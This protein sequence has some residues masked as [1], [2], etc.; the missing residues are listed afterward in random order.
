MCPGRGAELKTGGARLQPSPNFRGRRGSGAGLEAGRT[1]VARAITQGSRREGRVWRGWLSPRGRWVLVMQAPRRLRP[2]EVD[3]AGTSPRLVLSACGAA[4][5]RARRGREVFPDR[6]RWRPTAL[7]ARHPC[8]GI[9]RAREWSR[10]RSRPIRCRVAG[11]YKSQRISWNNR[12]APSGCGRPGLC[13][14]RAP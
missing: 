9:S 7:A 1:F 11:R 12:H 13:R 6:A 10:F 14:S 2:F 5:T 8:R 3:S 4:T